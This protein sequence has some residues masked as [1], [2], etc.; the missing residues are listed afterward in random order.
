[1]ASTTQNIETSAIEQLASPPKISLQILGTHTTNEQAEVI[2]FDIRIDCSKEAK[3]NSGEFLTSNESDLR[4]WDQSVES[5]DSFPT[6][7]YRWLTDWLSDNDSRRRYT[8]IRKLVCVP[9]DL[10]AAIKAHAEGLARQIAYG[11]S[12]KAEIHTPPLESDVLPQ[13][14][15]A[16]VRAEWSLGSPFI[17]AEQSWNMMVMNAMVNRKKGMISVND[18]QTSHGRSPF[19]RAHEN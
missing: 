3:I 4:S 17:A 12:I 11:G 6:T 15:T 18:R 8:G 16:V 5:S 9:D 13:E 7:S 19:R 14:Y 2:D 1:M 10:S